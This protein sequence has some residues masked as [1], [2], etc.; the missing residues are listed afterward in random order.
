MGLPKEL[1]KTCFFFVADPRISE[2]PSI[3]GPIHKYQD[4]TKKREQ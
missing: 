2:D 4:P 3:N 1:L